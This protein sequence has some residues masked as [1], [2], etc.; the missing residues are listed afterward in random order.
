MP[1]LAKVTDKA[2]PHVGILNSNGIENTKLVDVR[3]KKLCL[4]PIFICIAPAIKYAVISAIP[5]KIVFM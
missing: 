2:I 3:I 4:V 1:N 5:P